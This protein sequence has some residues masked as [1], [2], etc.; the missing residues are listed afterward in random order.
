M[1]LSTRRL[2]SIA[3]S[4]VAALQP[5][6]AILVQDGGAGLRGWDS[7]LSFGC[8]TTEDAFLNAAGQVDAA[9]RL[10]GYNVHSLSEGWW[11]DG[12]DTSS[13]CLSTGPTNGA[14]H[15]DKWGRLAP[16]P[17]KFPSAAHGFTQV[18]DAIHG[19]GARFGLR[20][21]LGIPKR[22]VALD[23]PIA[24]SANF[25][26]A[27]AANTSG[28]GANDCRCMSRTGGG[29]AGSSC[30][31]EAWPI[32]ATLAGRAYL[33]SLQQLY[34]ELWGVDVLYL[35]CDHAL[36][37]EA[38]LAFSREVVQSA[39]R[40]M[41]LVLVLR[42]ADP[43]LLQAVAGAVTAVQ[44][45]RGDRD[46]W[47]DTVGAGLPVAAR[48][49]QLL[50][51]QGAS[52]SFGVLPLGDVLTPVPSGVPITPDGSFDVPAT[53]AS[54][55]TAD[56]R[57]SLLTLAAI[58][59]APLVLGGV[60]ASVLNSSSGGYGGADLRLLSLQEV[61]TLNA[62]G[63]DAAPLS[64]L[65]LPFNA[66]QFGGGDAVNR[67]A[68]SASQLASHSSLR[69]RATNA[70]IQP[71]GTVSATQWPSVGLPLRVQPCNPESPDAST[72]VFALSDGDQSIR[73][74]AGPQLPNKADSEVDALP[75]CVSV[76]DGSLD[77]RAAVHVVPCPGGPA[78]A[79][80]WQWSFFASSEPVNIAIAAERVQGV[81]AISSAL[82]PPNG[83]VMAPYNA[84]AG[85]ST[86]DAVML[87]T[88]VGSLVDDGHAAP[89]PPPWRFSQLT[90]A[91]YITAGSGSNGVDSISSGE[92]C[93]MCLTVGSGVYAWT[94]TTHPWQ[95]ATYDSAANTGS[96]GAH[97]SPDALQRG[98]VSKASTRGIEDDGSVLYV[99]VSS[100]VDAA[101][102]MLSSYVS[103]SD[104]PL[105]FSHTAA[106]H[107]HQ[108]GR[109]GS[110][111]D[112]DNCDVVCDIRDVWTHKQ[113]L[114]RNGGFPV[115]L[116]GRSAVLYAIS[117]CFVSSGDHVV[118]PVSHET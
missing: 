109:F 5:A 101:Y 74:L 75:W 15:M 2:L 46:V 28:S 87:H 24:G 13:N 68:L 67:A 18:A 83:F 90:G 118:Q 66:S 58:T 22:A 34:S 105:P 7:T 99:A 104:L 54:L 43:E 79:Q 64:P 30:A 50:A 112:R 113:L 55:L 63:Q 36:P 44:V 52:L 16:A 10:Y 37:A 77:E 116:R 8:A 11:R 100:G 45:V 78:L 4:V 106:T 57:Q 6:R 72:Q 93:T 73:W 59:H 60:P 33:R 81:S 41:S 86:S 94:A 80:Q 61:L 31:G 47:E 19:L 39:P 62:D 25:T 107:S 117:N 97:S 3:A 82:L 21:P 51:G 56:E 108:S 111:V 95:Q 38:V 70:R 92:G 29:S 23:L 48:V 14:V 76:A 102:G 103:F 53:H 27:Q 35:Q 1:G 96:S 114:R 12:N 71:A 88:G 69:S 98:T 9:L 115:E 26:A 17:L 85:T 40:N 91:L 32:A 110:G 20:V 89:A 84:S 42:E 49:Y 65:A